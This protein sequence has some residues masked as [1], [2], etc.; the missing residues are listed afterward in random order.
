MTLTGKN[1]R[2]FIL[3]SQK[4]QQ[5]FKVTVAGKKDKGLKFIDQKSRVNPDLHIKIS[6]A[7]RLGLSMILI[8]LKRLGDKLKIQ[9]LFKKA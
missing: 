9:P 5:V 8:F 6:L 3:P 4:F 7:M 2:R 1:D